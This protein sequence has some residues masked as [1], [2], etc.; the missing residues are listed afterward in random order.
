MTGSA[1]VVLAACAATVVVAMALTALA[2]HRTGRWS[3]V[4]VTWGAGFVAL[5]AVAA[6]VGDGN[7]WRRLLFVLLVGVWGLRLASHI[8][9]RARGHGE[10]PRYEVI[11][12]EGKGGIVR[13]VLAPQGMSLWFIALPVQVAA[14][15]DRAL[16]W[17][18]VLGILVW[19]IGLAFEAVGDAQLAGF[20]ADP[21]NRGKVMDRGLWG[22]TR[23]PNYVGDACL[24]WGLWLIA[25]DSGWRG[26]AMVLS[27]VAMTF[28][29]RNV[30]G[31]KLLEKT[32]ME[33]PG[34][35]AY[36]KRVPMF[37]P[38]PPRKP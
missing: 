24:W 27:P 22:W 4:D 32:M 2:A 35:P 28:F 33:R 10:D 36:A 13:R 11:K 38:R 3:V 7:L 18:G 23:H 30:T 12:G 8:L 31:A 26:A 25:A 1:W 16:G 19:A 34:Y 5:A 6:V 17:L 14:V 37:F 20:R 15:S 9:R 29:I 21:A